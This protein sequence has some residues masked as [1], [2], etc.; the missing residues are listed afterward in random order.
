MAVRAGSRIPAS[1]PETEATTQAGTWTAQQIAGILLTLP[2]VGLV[3]GFITAEALYP[4]AYSIKADSLSH[5]GAT[6]PPNSVVLQPSATIFDVSVLVAGAML[7]GAAFFTYRAFQLK[8]VSLPIG[9]LAI[10]VLGVGVFPLTNPNV[11]TIFAILAF[12]G[13][14]IAMIL[15][16][17]V[18]PRVFRHIWQA[19]GAVSLVAITAAFVLKDFG[20]VAGL[21]EGGTERWNVYPILLWLIAFGTCLMVAPLGR[22]QSPHLSEAGQSTPRG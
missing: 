19:L 4:R 2:G 6:E 5:L 1:A 17:S 20:P 3:L 14:G 18:A 22:R 10:G 16:S 8:R 21:G 12:F 11:H 9:A 7:V 13:G 15:A